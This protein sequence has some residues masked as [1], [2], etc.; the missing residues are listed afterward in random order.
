MLDLPDELIQSPGINENHIY[1]FNSELQTF[2][3]HIT[4]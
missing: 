1:K 2:S 3:L 4:T